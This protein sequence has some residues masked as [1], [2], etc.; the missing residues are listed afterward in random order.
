MLVLAIVVME[1]EVRRQVHWQVRWV[2]REF[3]LQ[4]AR[5]CP[6]PK[7]LLL[8]SAAAAAKN[9]APTMVAFLVHMVLVG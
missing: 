3:D 8:R 5:G 7:V 4:E 6:R 1:G 9:A 2:L